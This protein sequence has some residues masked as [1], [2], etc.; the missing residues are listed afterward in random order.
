MIWKTNT[1]FDSEKGTA[2]MMVLVASLLLGTACIAL[3][4]AV[5]ASSQNNTDAL[6]ES[7]AYWAAESGLQRTIDILRH[8][9]VTYSQASGTNGGNMSTWLGTSGA[10]TVSDE[11]SYTVQVSDPDNTSTSTTY[12]VTGYF[13]QADGSYLTSRTFG[14]SPNTTTISYDP[15]QDTVVSHPMTGGTTFGRFQIVSTGSG[16]AVTATEF[17]LDYR[18]VVPTGASRMLRGDISATGSITFDDYSPASLLGSTINLCETQACS[19]PGASFPLNLPMSVQLTPQYSATFYGQMSAAEPTR[20]LVR[21]TGYG[22]NS[23]QKILEGVIQKNFLNGLGSDNALTFLGRTDCIDF[24]LGNSSQLDINGGTSPSIGVIS[25]STLVTVNTELG[26]N[27]TNG[28]ITPPP[29]VYIGN[30]L[31][32]WQQSPTALDAVIRQFRQTAQNS[33]RYFTSGPTDDTWGNFATGTGITFCEGDCTMNGHDEGG[34]ILVVT[35]TFTT[36]G[37]PSF[38]GLVLVTGSGGVIRGGGGQENFLGNTIIAPY[39]PNNLAAGWGCPVYNQNGGAGNTVNVG[40]DAT[41]DGTTAI[42]NF[43]I[44]VAEK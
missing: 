28:T 31:P 1:N 9:G 8:Q 39:N 42:S 32:D 33:G 40:L 18:M 36:Q 38:R 41:L 26:Q 3:L 12:R 5:G 25:T 19:T 15:V 14:T 22:P 43:M 17:K 16:A 29:D 7:K 23:S 27:N 44:G 35:G 24:Q 20:L 6:S 13:E 11:A 10:V 37:A 2:L 34:G 4:T 21:A 30:E